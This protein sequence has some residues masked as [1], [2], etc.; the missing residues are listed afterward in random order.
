MKIVGIIVGPM[1]LLIWLIVNT[2]YTVSK[3]KKEVKDKNKDT[4]LIVKCEK[5]KIEHEA[6]V[7]EF[8]STHMSKTKSV[9]VSANV[10]PLGV[11]GTH[12]SYLAKKF[13][14]PNCNKK[15][16]S[17]IKNYNEIAKDNTKIMI[18]FILK[19]FASLLIGGALI[20]FVVEL[21]V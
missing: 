17:E 21:F 8:F 7:D 11:S 18:P 19:Y 1:L 16:W 3:I 13:F 15:T 2:I 6:T 14:C 5:C 20:I 12:Y 10:G 9:V 4:K